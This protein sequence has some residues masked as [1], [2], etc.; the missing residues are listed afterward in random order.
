MLGLIE[1]CRVLPDG[2]DKSLRAH[3]D[4][5]EQMLHWTV[6]NHSMQRRSLNHYEEH[7]RHL[8]FG[9][10]HTVRR[11]A[12]RSVNPSLATLN[13]TTLL[14]LY[15]V[16]RPLARLSVPSACRVIYP[17][18]YLLIDVK[19]ISLQAWLTI[20]ILLYLSYV[21]RDVEA[22]RRLLCV[23]FCPPIFWLRRLLLE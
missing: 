21:T 23:D 13:F 9:S 22:S 11:H 10:L 14:W 17:I 6:R 2:F 7:K 20:L 5:T 16:N 12:I 19:T 18:S 1:N 8:V 3:S 15:S 4:V